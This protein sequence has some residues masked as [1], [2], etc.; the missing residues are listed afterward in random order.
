LLSLGCQREA[1]IPNDKFHLTVQRVIVDSD[2]V[3]SVLKIRVPHG[4]RIS[5]DIERGHSMVTVPPDAAD[6]AAKEGQIALSASRITRQGDDFAYVQT[7]IRAESS[8]HSFASLGPNVYAIPAATKLEAYFSI[9]ATDG[10]Y[11]QDTPIEIAR[12][13]GKPVMLVVGEP[14]KVR[15]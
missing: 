3:V 9:S 15:R 12:L 14:N 11:L 4:A 7:L 1:A 13:D 6:G 8:K 2:V 10:D 5:I